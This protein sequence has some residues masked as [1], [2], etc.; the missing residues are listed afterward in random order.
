MVPFY[1]RFPDLALKEIRT[2]TIRGYKG[3]PNGAYAFVEY[4]CDETNCDC[5]RVFINVISQDTGDETLATINYGWESAEFYIEWMGDDEDIDELK[6]PALAPWPA[7]QTKLAP[8]L[9][10][11]FKEAAL[12]DEEYI[13]RLRR[14]YRMFKQAVR[15]KHNLPTTKQ[16]ARNR[17]RRTKSRKRRPRRKSG[18]R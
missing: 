5:R 13:K 7:L 16:P 11:L 10:E 8:Y 2:A 14:H 17:S 3:L 6:G 4:Y 9:L 18:R 15:T 1:T 12:E